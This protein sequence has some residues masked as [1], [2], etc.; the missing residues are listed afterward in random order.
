VS[1]VDIL[2]KELLKR[3]DERFDEEFE[4]TENEVI[5]NIK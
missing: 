3:L 1:N 4:L 5:G 2:L